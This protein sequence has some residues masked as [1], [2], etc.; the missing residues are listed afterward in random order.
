MKAARTKRSSR[1]NVPLLV[2]F[3]FFGATSATALTHMIWFDMCIEEYTAKRMPG[4]LFSRFD[5]HSRYN[6]GVFSWF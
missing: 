4:F 1:V 6:D 2:L 3:S 5:P